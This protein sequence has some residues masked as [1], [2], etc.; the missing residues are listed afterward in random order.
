[1]RNGSMNKVASG[2]AAAA[3]LPGAA[4]A[5]QATPPAPATPAP[6][7]PATSATPPATATVP[8]ATPDGLP[9]GVRAVPV[10]PAAAPAASPAPAASGAAA[11]GGRPPADD[12]NSDEPDVV[13]TGQRGLPGAVV[14]DIP[15]EQQLGPADI[16]SYGVGSVS[17]LLTELAPQIRSGRGSGGAPVV[18]LNGRR[19]SGFQEIR[20]L[21]TEAIAR[22]DILPEEVALKYGYAADQKVVNFVLRRRFRATTVELADR[23]PTEGGRNSP[24]ANVDL[25]SIRNA[26][27]INVHLDYSRSAGLTEAQRDIAPQPSL[28][29]QAGNVVASAGGVIDPRYGG[30]TV[31]GVPA[32]AASGA[33]GIGQFAPGMPNPADQGAFR[34]LLPSTRALTANMVYATNILADKVG[35]T[36]NAELETSDSTSL[37]GLPSAVFA[38]PAGNPFSPFANPVLVDRALGDV[39]ALTQN[40]SSVT[41]HLGSTFNGNVGQWRWSLTGNLD[42]VASKTFTDTGVDTAAFQALLTAGDAAANPFGPIPI[43][44]ATGLGTLP[45]SYARSTS[46]SGGVNALVNGTLLDLPAGPVSTAVRVGASANDFSSDS[47]RAGTFSS[48]DLSRG[49]VDG[50]INV[51]VP[52]TSR[53]KA[54]LGAIG[55]LSVNGNLAVR[56]LSDFGTLTT[57]GVGFNWSPR[58]AIRVIGSITDQGDAPS[59]QQLGNP[60]IVTPNVRVFDYVLGTTSTVT[61]IGGGNPALLAD[62]RHTAKLEL[63]LKP[64]KTKDVTFIANYVTAHTD[65]AIVGFPTPTAEIE[66]AFPGRF[67]RDGG[68]NLTRL[69]TRP[70]NFAR[71]ERSEIRYG[72]NF[73]HPLKSRLQKQIEAFRAGKG[74]NPLAGLPTPDFLRRQGGGQGGEQRGGQGGGQG[75]GQGGRPGGDGAPPPPTGQGASPTSGTGATTGGTTAPGAGGVGGGGRGGFGGG[76]GPGGG[77][78]R[79]GQGGGRLQFALYHTWHFT[80]RVLVSA[81]GPALDLLNGDAIGQSGGSPRH[82]L[83]AQAGYVNNGLGVRLSGNYASGTQVNGGLVGDAGSAGNASGTTALAFSSLTTLNLRLFADATGRI[84]LLVKHPWLR[85]VR[86]T[87]A[88]DNVFDSRQR[89]TDQT[90]ATPISYQPD[91]LNP[92][93]RTVRVSIRKLFF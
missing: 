83:E 12:A 81:N 54:V 86:A 13:V 75:A 38:L 51:D 22:V 11:A 71:A 7:T 84:D 65:N 17:D 21:P 62:R 44:G 93:G 53:G 82:E 9:T 42:H 78:G 69:D 37:Q 63:N 2:L 3:M 89:V 70:I 91:Y 52:L 35:A 45:G 85:G 58:D 24:A 67:T 10:D 40:R 73:S 79:G 59:Q 48:A 43:G 34:S 23:Q 61:T 77:G 57:R 76:R 1:M 87:L 74:P 50:Q 56:H 92:L 15:P 6:A 5:Q 46:T 47:Y 8:T 18:L 72:I 14:G 60:V 27:R 66:A 49:I 30:A 68:G 31:A 20:D 36:F 29:A 26:G 25:L 39:G 64:W 88:F 90:G 16:R 55:T 28:F 32:A 19:I 33:A 41:G 80:D 4:T